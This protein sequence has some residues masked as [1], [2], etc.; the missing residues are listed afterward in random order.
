MFLSE[1][2]QTPFNVMHCEQVVSKVRNQRMNLSLYSKHYAESKH[3]EVSFEFLYSFCIY[4]IL[5]LLQVRINLNTMKRLNSQVEFLGAVQDYMHIRLW[6]HWRWSFFF[7]FSQPFK[8]QWLLYVPP[9]SA[10][11]IS[12]FCPQMFVTKTM[13]NLS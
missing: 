6:K 5:V 2:I 8:S 3:M 10:Y 11:Y 7:W 12:A 1:I 13:I 9:V 4:Y